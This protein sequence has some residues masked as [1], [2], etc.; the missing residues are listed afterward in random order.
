MGRSG[1]FPRVLGSGKRME[2]LGE[3]KEKSPRVPPNRI[4]KRPS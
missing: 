4:A 2:G 3:D 1:E